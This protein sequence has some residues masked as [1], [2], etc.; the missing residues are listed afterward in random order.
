MTRL[1]NASSAGGADDVTAFLRDLRRLRGQAGLKHDEL[2]RR[3]HFP[4][5][6]LKAAERGPDLPTL[7]VLEAYVRGCGAT[8]SEWEDRWRRLTPAPTL[9]LSLPSRGP[10]PAR[11]G[12]VGP[13]APAPTAVPG[14]RI[15]DRELASRLVA[16]LDAHA[17]PAR[18]APPFTPPHPPGAPPAPAPAAGP[19]L[20]P[21]SAASG[22]APS[23]G[24]AAE[25]SP[26]RHHPILRRT[27]TVVV[28]VV[29]ILLAAGAALWFALPSAAAGSGSCAVSAVRTADTAHLPGGPPQPGC[30]R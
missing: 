11:P 21:A 6:T 30:R 16:G 8:P 25:P 13:L 24:P 1:R 26:R 3:A 20:A 4:E 10:S 27:R 23:P 17:F 18:P 2:A 7:P 9:G 14:P 15:A 12:G 29:A 5:D 19:A 22:P 28:L